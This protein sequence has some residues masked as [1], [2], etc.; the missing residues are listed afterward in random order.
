MEREIKFIP[1]EIMCFKCLVRSM[2]QTH[3]ELLIGQVHEILPDMYAVGTIDLMAHW[4]RYSM[5]KKYIH[6]VRIYTS[7]L[8]S[9]ENHMHVKIASGR[10]IDIGHGRPTIA[11]LKKG[12]VRWTN[13]GSG[14][15]TVVDFDKDLFHI[16]E[17]GEDPS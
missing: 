9:K 2:C 15:N 8:T 1:N 17:H 6:Q 3:C 14:I 11:P 7:Y 16:V 5:M 4:L 13:S 12:L 10:I